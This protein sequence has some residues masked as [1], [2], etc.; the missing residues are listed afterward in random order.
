LK[1]E[2]AL[3]SLLKSLEFAAPDEILMYHINYFNQINPLLQEVFK[4]RVVGNI[5]LPQGFIHKLKSAIEKKKKVSSSPVAL[6]IRERETLQLMAENLSNQEI[7]D[8][9]FI[10]LNTVKTRLKDLYVKLEVDSRTKA[11]EKAKQMRLI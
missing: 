6:T 7:A 1:K 8:K 10:S 4:K 3:D 11:V 5:N 9:L 2:K